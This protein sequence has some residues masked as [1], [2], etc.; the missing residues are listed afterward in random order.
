MQIEP[1]APWWFPPYEA[2]WFDYAEDGQVI[3]TNSPLTLINFTIPSSAIGVIRWFG[4]EVCDIT[5]ENLVT[6]RIKV[7]GA[8][9][10]VY[11]YVKGIIST[12]KVPTETLIRLSKGAKVQLEVS[13]TN[14][15]ALDI[16]GRIKG[17]WWTEDYSKVI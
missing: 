4:Q 8:P 14:T 16:I 15:S 2:W 9:D 5:K 7:N 13:T 3:N 17:W 6:W 10:E 1:I 11:G 12:I